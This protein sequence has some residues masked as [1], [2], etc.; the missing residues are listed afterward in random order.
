[1]DFNIKKPSNIFALIMMILVFFLMFGLPML[2]YFNIIS[3]NETV[4]MDQIPESVRQT[5]E[6]IAFL[7]QIALLMVIPIMAVLLWYSLV[8]KLTIKEG[9]SHLKLKLEG[10]DAAFLWGIISGIV[11][12]VIGIAISYI[13][14]MAKQNPEGNVQQILEYFSI[15]SAFILVTIQPISEEIF[16]RGFL[17]EKIGSFF[18]EIIAIFATAILFGLAHMGYGGYY[19]VV[20][21]MLLGLILGAV[22]VKTKNL[23]S[24]IIAHILFNFTVFMLAIFSTSLT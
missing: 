5:I 23:Y 3:S 11:M 12:L 16:F 14:V 15:P 17:L 9:I 21:P 6:I 19:P 18:G 24:S 7:I 8:N 10:I 22:V 4:Q 1:M 20:F 13:L 2:S